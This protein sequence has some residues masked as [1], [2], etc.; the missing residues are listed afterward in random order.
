MLNC[1][2]A[3]NNYFND[4]MRMTE[5][6]K[7]HFGIKLV[8][9]D[10]KMIRKMPPKSKVECQ[11]SDGTKYEGTFISYDCFAEILTINVSK[12]NK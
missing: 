5:E 6:V 4:K 9:E 7:R 2:P 11:T 3:Y 10:L 8:G 12:I 1:I